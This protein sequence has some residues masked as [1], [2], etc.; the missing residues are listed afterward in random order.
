MA[1][2]HHKYG[3]L[4]YEASVENSRENLPKTPPPRVGVAFCKNH[5]F[6]REKRMF[7]VFLCVFLGKYACFLLRLFLACFPVF[8]V[9]RV[10]FALV[11]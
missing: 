9:F 11:F 1:K 3:K 4:A 7:L 2:K 8:S 5:C 6:S 10:R